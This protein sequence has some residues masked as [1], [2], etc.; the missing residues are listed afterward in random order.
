[1]RKL[2]AKS[3]SGNRQL[4]FTVHVMV[5]FA[6]MVEKYIEVFID[7]FSVFGHS[8]DCCLANLE[9]LIRHCVEANLVLN[10]EKCHF[11][12]QEGIVFQDCGQ[13]QATYLKLVITSLH[14]C[15]QRK[16]VGPC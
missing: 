11:M 5:I 9:H 7:D 13:V 10:W 2:S 6:D 12:V 1:M 15:P 14:Q 4:F 8:F 3:R 16:V